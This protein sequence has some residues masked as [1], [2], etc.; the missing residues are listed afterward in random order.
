[1]TRTISVLLTVATLSP[2]AA[3]ARQDSARG[4]ASVKDVMT[5]MTI[6]ASDVIFDAASSPPATDA[7]WAA[8]R[9]AADTLAASGRLPMTAP[10]AR[11]SKTWMEMARAMVTQGE[12]TM[13]VA[14][15]KARAR[16]EAAS[17]AVYTTCEACH[18][19][20]LQP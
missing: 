12:A 9:K 8:V 16:L 2:V 11:D 14:D 1:M 6:P 20:Y 4:P 10:L 3:G 19:R 18:A 7:A 5:S 17:D 13:E 15:A